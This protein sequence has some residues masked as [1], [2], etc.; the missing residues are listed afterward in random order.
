MSGKCLLITG[1]TGFIGA[2]LARRLAREGNHVR[3][4][5]DD[6]RGAATSR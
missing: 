4:F 2:A 1:G 3:V 6:S 5:D